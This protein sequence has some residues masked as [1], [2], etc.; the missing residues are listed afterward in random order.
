MANLTKQSNDYMCLVKHISCV[1]YTND[2]AESY[3]NVCKARC[4]TGIYTYLDTFRYKFLI[5]SHQLVFMACTY[6]QET[7]YDPNSEWVQYT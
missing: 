3:N 5:I 6:L 7:G 1:E 2:W 4:P